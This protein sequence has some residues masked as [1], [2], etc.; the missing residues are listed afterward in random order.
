MTRADLLQ[1]HHARTHQEGALVLAKSRFIV[2]TKSSV[3]LK[4]TIVPLIPRSRE[5]EVMQNF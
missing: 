3:C 5:L 2:D 4:N 1:K